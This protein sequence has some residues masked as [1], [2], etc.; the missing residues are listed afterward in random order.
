M[1]NGKKWIDFNLVKSAVSMEMLIIHLGLL[2]TSRKGDDVR[3]KCPFHN[4][5][6]DN[7]MAINLASNSFY[8]FGCKARGNL[9]E[10]VARYKDCSISEAA[11]RLDEWFFISGQ[12]TES[13]EVSREANG[14][15]SESSES[16]PP[17]TPA[18]LIASIEH[19]LARLKQLISSR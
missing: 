6:S 19:Q 15:V 16:V 1:E 9:L 13:K 8:C 11:Q 4:G 18:H 3:L 2:A 7:S 5:K 10:F 17:I 12:P 14:D